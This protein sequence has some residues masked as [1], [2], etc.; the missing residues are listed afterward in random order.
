MPNSSRHR[1]HQLITPLL[2]GL[3]IT[4]LIAGVAVY[5]SNQHLDRKIT[6]FEQTGYLAIPSRDIQPGLTQFGSAIWGGLFFTLSTGA[7][8]SLLT[9]LALRSGIFMSTFNRRLPLILLG[10]PIGLLFWIN[11]DGFNPIATL[12][13]T[14]VPAG[15]ALFSGSGKPYPG[16]RPSMVPLLAPFIALLILTGAWLTQLDSRLFINIRDF[17][18]LSN[19]VGVKINDFYYRYTLF[20][21]EVFKTLSQKTLRSYTLTARENNPVDKRLYQRLKQ[22]D[23]LPVKDIAAADIEIRSSG[24]KLIFE[25]NGRNLL[26]TDRQQLMK[27]TGKILQELSAQ[28][29][30]FAAFRKVT[31]FSILFAFPVILFLFFYAVLLQIFT[32]FLSDK[33]SAIIAA[34]LVLGLGLAPLVALHGAGTVPISETGLARMLG[35][36]RWQDRILALRTIDQKKFEIGDF[37][38]YKRML[39]SPHLTERYWLAR[40]LGQSRNPDTYAD[41]LK[42]LHDPHSNVVCQAFYGLGQRGNRKAVAAILKKIETLN[43]WY[44]QRYGYSALKKLGWTQ[45]DKAR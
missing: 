1:R 12:L 5:R 22:F 44:S 16:A 43:D 31:F 10:I 8:L 6:A 7:G 41:L 26:E 3:L 38:G 20:P 40:A 37:P 13:V 24:S 39:D 21:A 45:P 25:A 17:V 30:R 2:L 15:V 14:A 27:Q 19:P 4:Q 29:D 32:F 42:L 34:V 23:Y 36:E 18:L 35:S 33:L 9:L 11:Q 28:A